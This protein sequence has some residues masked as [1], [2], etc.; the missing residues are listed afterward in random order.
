M[1]DEK[2]YYPTRPPVLTSPEESESECVVDEEHP[3]EHESDSEIDLAHPYGKGL[4]EKEVA[5][6]KEKEHIQAAKDNLRMSPPKGY[7]RSRAQIWEEG[8][9]PVVLK[10]GRAAAT[11]EQQL[12][13][14]NKSKEP[15]KS[16][17]AQ[18]QKRTESFEEITESFN[19]EYREVL[20]ILPLA[21]QP[22][23]TRHGQHSFTKAVGKAR[24]EILLRQKALKPKNHVDG[25]QIQTRSLPL[26]ENVQ[27][28][29]RRAF[30]MCGLNE[31]GEIPSC[32]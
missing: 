3:Y 19:V 20:A 31:S 23:S 5:N 11:A 10:K 9:E 27:A 14:E 18:Q 17:K 13:K 8:A 6:V 30:A 21:L 12:P 26:G 4:G 2:V 28:V 22:T 24:I 25:T 1:E 15:P 32:D 29:C 7:K 16:S